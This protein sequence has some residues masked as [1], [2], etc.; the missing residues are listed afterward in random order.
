MRAPTEYLVPGDAV[1]DLTSLG[2]TA[3]LGSRPT[4]ITDAVCR[5][6]SSTP[7]A[8]AG[9]RSDAE[10]LSGRLTSLLALPDHTVL[11]ATTGAEA[12]DMALQLARTATRRRDV[13]CVTGSYHG[14]TAACLEVCGIAGWG[15]GS[16]TLRLDLIGNPDRALDALDRAGPELAAVILEPIMSN[17]G[18]VPIPDHVAASVAELARRHGALLIHDEVGCGLG[19]TGAWRAGA[20]GLPDIVLVGKTLGAGIY[21]IAAVLALP[22]VVKRGVGRGRSFSLSWTPPACAAALAFLSEVEKGNLVPRAKELGLLL[23]LRLSARLSGH[24]WVAGVHGSGLGFGIELRP[25][26]ADQRISLSRRMRER[27]VLVEP[28]PSLPGLRAMPALT[29]PA[30]LLHEGFDVVAGV[31]GEAVT[32]TG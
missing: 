20:P 26:F 22:D 9:S 11:R 13:A 4:G 18:F 7:C 31:V 25:D 27:G 29:M 16:E 10:E 3:P 6:L 19:R 28:T 23:R 30:E 21:P 32:G 15:T 2:G 14:G 17:R 24:P 1:L 12:V 5:V 8:P